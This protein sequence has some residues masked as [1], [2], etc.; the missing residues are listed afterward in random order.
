[1]RVQVAKWGNSLA[2]RLPGVCLR[3]AGVKHGDAL[4]VDVTPLGEIRLTPCPAPHR[5]EKTAFLDQ[6]RRLQESWP[7]T[8]SVVATMRQSDRY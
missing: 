3:Q 5:F 1:M 2:V 7:I 8:D 4:D 6:L